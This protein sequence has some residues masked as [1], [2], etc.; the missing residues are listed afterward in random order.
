MSDTD[1]A[2]PD[3]LGHSSVRVIFGP[4]RLDDVG[5]LARE[6]GAQRIL[7]VSDGGVVAAGHVDRAVA[8]LGD[9]GI[10]TRVFADVSVNPT[11]DEVDAGVRFCQSD[12]P[13]FVIGLG[14]G[15][16]MDCAK[17]INLLLTNGGRMTD[18]RGE[19]PAAKPML[20]MILI[21]TTAGTGS[22]AQS[23]ALIS[24]ADT[25]QKM[26]CGDRRLPTEGGLRPRV[27]ILD[28]EL[29]ETTP[30]EVTAMAGIDAVAHAVESAASTRRNEIS[31]SL[32][33]EAWRRLDAYLER[34]I[35][36]PGDSTAR[37]EM[38][39]GAHLAGVAIE[40]SML[41][42][43]HACANPLTARYGLIHGVAVGVMLP[44]VIRFNTADG[45]NPYDDLGR[46]SDDLARRI[47]Q[48]LSAA[49]LPRTLSD[50]GVPRAGLDELSVE[51]AEQWTA[52][53]NPVPLRPEGAAIL[54]AA[55]FDD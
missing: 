21:P 40:C 49:G 20:P 2:L 34:V 37:A 41:G 43:A 28:P 7:L 16:A 53:F 25:H 26:A 51:A 42:A 18:H 48:L 44:H 47:E 10:E 3:I 6:E 24:D 29:M 45:S 15:S 55:A 11:T 23:F 19:G 27:A 5:V 31:R 35:A 22:E 39:L 54:Y 52:A 4:G 50:C 8:S 1:A 30:P 17:G 32:S 36:D 33:R 9:A 38:L 12:T 46:T 13:D 14:G